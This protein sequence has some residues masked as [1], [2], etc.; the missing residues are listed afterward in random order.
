MLKPAIKSINE[1]TPEEISFAFPSNS[2]LVTHLD[3]MSLEK[4]I[5]KAKDNIN[6]CEVV[7]L[8]DGS[9]IECTYGHINTLIDIASYIHACTRGAIMEWLVPTSAAP[10]SYLCDHCATIAVSYDALIFPI[11]QITVKQFDTIRKLME[12]GLISSNPVINVASDASYYSCHTY[13]CHRLLDIKRSITMKNIR[14][15]LFGEES[16]LE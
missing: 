12:I 3:R 15:E 9:I 2:T 7:I 8:D 11:S 6:Y 14:H 5:E 13:T 10:I 4:F 1:L 16:N